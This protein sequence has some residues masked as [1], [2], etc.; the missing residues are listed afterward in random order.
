[1]RI[2][3]RELLGR[4]NRT[5]V[6]IGRGA[7][8]APIWPSGITGS[9]AH[10]EAVAVAAVSRTSDIVSLGID[11][12][13]HEPLPEGIADEIS[14]QSEQRRYPRSWLESR[15][16]FVA[17]EAVYK[18][19]H[20]VDGVFLDFRDVEVDLAKGIALTSYG[21]ALSV[22]IGTGSHVLAIARVMSH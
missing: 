19:V 1:V 9:L 10:D 22:E 17:K 6:V 5:N 8:G 14:T 21:R 15:R 7:S 18:A 13:P 20:P 3:A 12:E 2:L 11:I 16:L 4:L